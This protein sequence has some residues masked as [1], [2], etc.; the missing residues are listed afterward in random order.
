MVV[1]DGS[2]L[3]SGMGVSALLSCP[4]VPVSPTLPVVTS[5]PVSKH[6]YTTTN[7]YVD[8][9]FYVYINQHN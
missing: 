7:I 5:N 9:D 8:N 3:G 4:P 6:N 2:A 1:V